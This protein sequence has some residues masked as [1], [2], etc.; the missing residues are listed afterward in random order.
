MPGVNLEVMASRFDI[1]DGQLRYSG[2]PN[3]LVGWSQL[4]LLILYNAADVFIT[5]SRGE[6]FGLTVAEAL[7]CGVPVIAQNVSAIPEVVGPG[8]VLLDP[9]R[10]HTV[11]AGP[12]SGPPDPTARA[13]WGERGCSGPPPPG[14]SDGVG[15]RARDCLRHR[16]GEARNA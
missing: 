5:T 10:L 13:A 6:G 16:R 12:D 8:G 2:V 4:W 14:G 3:S 15:E 11:P 7:A 9:E 1:R